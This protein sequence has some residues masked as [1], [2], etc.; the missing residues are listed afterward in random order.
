M[1]KAMPVLA[2]VFLTLAVTSGAVAASGLL[3][4][5]DVKDRSLTGA[6]IKKGS[7]GVSLLTDSAEAALRGAT[8]PR[9]GRGVAGL[10]GV[11]GRAGTNG[12]P[13]ATGAT[14]ATGASGA[15]GD[16]GTLGAPGA[17]G[18][19]GS[20]GTVTP[21]SATAGS[22]L[23]P[24]ATPP[25]TIVSLSVPAGKYVLLA[26]TQLTHSGAGDTVEC[27]LNAGGPALDTVAMKTLPALASIPVSL[28]AVTTVSSP[29]AV[30]VACDV[31]VANGSAAFTS[32]IAIPTS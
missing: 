19:A 24:T 1:K 5:A 7:L 25:T 16:A 2:A 3:T 21:L 4:G 27:T 29:L 11:D 13:G 28:Q 15:T 20:N 10:P 23:L 6:D 22:V 17:D 32:L 9:G 30:T 12:G 14:G 8:G 31:T 18:L 26:K